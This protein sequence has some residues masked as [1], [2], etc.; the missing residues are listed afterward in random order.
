VLNHVSWLALPALTFE[1]WVNHGRRLGSIGRT[2]GW[3]IGDWLRFGN[4]AYGEKYARASRI[5]GYDVQTLMNMS[6]VATRIEPSRRRENLS[7]SHHA[8]V[9]ALPAGEREAWLNRA[10]EQHFSV[11]DL[12]LEVRQERNRGSSDALADPTMRAG[13]EAE[14]ITTCPQCGHRFQ[15]A[16]R[17][18]RARTT[19]TKS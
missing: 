5:T 1:Q 12:R 10:E 6:Y 4:A 3:W 9:A 8:E 18:R 2:V 13:S 11:H 14:R 17:R 7:W 19:S 15:E 16:R